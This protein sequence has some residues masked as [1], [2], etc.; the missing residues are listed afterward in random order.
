MT[1][2]LKSEESD[3]EHKR[4]D[5]FCDAFSEQKRNDPDGQMCKNGTDL[6]EHEHGP[7]PKTAEKPD[8]ARR[9]EYG[10]K[11]KINDPCGEST[12]SL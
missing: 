5:T 10:N 1:T 12:T 7:S 8:A 6:S 2:L 9:C 4:D 3:T 11:L